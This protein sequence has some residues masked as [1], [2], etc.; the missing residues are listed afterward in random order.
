[1]TRQFGWVLRDVGPAL[2][3]LEVTA[4]AF[5]VREA[6]R[7]QELR[8]CLGVLH[9][10]PFEAARHDPVAEFFLENRAHRFTRRRRGR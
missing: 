9:H 10:E 5:A 1:M 4:L 2:G 8:A 3:Y 6:Q 7:V